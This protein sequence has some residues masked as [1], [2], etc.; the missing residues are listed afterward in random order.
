MSFSP[1]PN[2]QQPSRDPDE[3]IAVAI[4]FGAIAAIL[5]WILGRGSDG[6]GVKRPSFLANLFQEEVVSEGDRGKSGE[7]ILEER[8]EPF[9]Q[10]RES[11]VEGKRPLKERKTLEREEREVVQQSLSAEELRDREPL[12]EETPKAAMK[13]VDVPENYWAYGAIAALSDRKVIEGF[14]DGTFQPDKPIT[15]AE[16]AAQIP[17]VFEQPGSES[18]PDF[19]DVPEEFWAA[20]KIDETVKMGFMQGY[21]GDVFRPDQE[22]TRLE[23]LVTLA[24]GLNLKPPAA[25]GE[26]LEQ[27]R[28]REKIDNWAVE[29]IAAATE[30]G[31]TE[32][33][34]NPEQLNPSQTATRAELASMLYQ[35]LQFTEQSE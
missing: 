32:G 16:F 7:A 18:T 3:W 30:A 28:D 34:P 24:T 14:P 11:R 22:I 29:Q 4:A 35:A 12:E 33:L 9:L 2:P 17:N 25:P 1:E 20:E 5:F 19:N 23:A 6:L 26:I 21:P 13:F 15:R 27:Y 10:E 8:D 31:L